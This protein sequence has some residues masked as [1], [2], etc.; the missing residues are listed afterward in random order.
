M[1]YE[2]N[3]NRAVI[4]IMNLNFVFRSLFL[5][6]CL[7]VSAYISVYAQNNLARI[8]SVGNVDRQ[9][10]GAVLKKISGTGNFNFV[11]NN[12]TVPADSVV[13]VENYRGTIY[14]LLNN[15]LGADYEF[16]EVPGY[17]VCGTPPAN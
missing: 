5:I 3:L 2:I 10:I 17:I 11:Y 6:P 7:V 1:R 13:S 9:Q 14:N 4:K 8:V 15:L 12:Q 16:K